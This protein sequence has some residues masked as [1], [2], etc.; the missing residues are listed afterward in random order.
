MEQNCNYTYLQRSSL[1][2][3]DVRSDFMPTGRKRKYH[4]II[5]NQLETVKCTK[6]MPMEV[7]MRN[8]FI[9]LAATALFSL[10]LLV[11]NPTW[12][13]Q[14]A[15]QKKTSTNLI[16]SGQSAG[17]II[18][19]TSDDIVVQKTGDQGDV[20]FSAK[21]IEEK[22]WEQTLKEVF[23][24]KEFLKYLT[25][26]DRGC[27]EYT[28]LNI[29]SIVG[30][31]VSLKIDL[32]SDCGGAHPGSIEFFMASDLSRSGDFNL[33]RDLEPAKITKLTDYFA[34]S[35]VFKALMSDSVVQKTLEQANKPKTIAQLIKTA[36]RIIVQDCD[37]YIPHDV[38][39]Q[40]AFHHIEDGK[41]AVRVNLPYYSEVCRG[42]SIQLDLLLPIP[43][44]LKTPLQ[45]AASRKEGFLMK[46]RTIVPHERMTEFKFR[47]KP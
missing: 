5:P 32:V 10:T 14:T 33:S 15:L 18:T 20:V 3:V 30:S 39:S 1:D 41:V 28:G 47:W 27:Y 38:L 29:L 42:Q 17:F 25:D 16:W 37:Y 40:F 21:A 19:W 31:I 6:P 23:D 4:R 35:T 12:A 8:R 2:R 24:D 22:E 44:S 36:R 26:G 11:G 9:A 43:E 13:E 45:Q 7:E 46:D 34:E